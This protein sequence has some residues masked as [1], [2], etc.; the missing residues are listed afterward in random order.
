MALISLAV[1]T[2]LF[3]SSR[4]SSNYFKTKLQQLKGF[5]EKMRINP[6]M[7]IYYFSVKKHS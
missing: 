1:K 3:Y 2:D 5:L 4:I 7:F 6:S